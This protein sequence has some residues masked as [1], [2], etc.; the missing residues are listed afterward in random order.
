MGRINFEDHTL[1]KKWWVGKKMN[2][3]SGTIKDE[4]KTG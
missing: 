2:V 3:M 4:K 1:I